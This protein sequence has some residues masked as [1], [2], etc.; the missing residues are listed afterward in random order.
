MLIKRCVVRMLS[1]ELVVLSAGI[2]FGQTYPNRPIRVVTS[3]AGGG[4]DF[5][6]RLIAQGISGPLGQ[7]VV[8][9]NRQVNLL[10]EIVAKAPPD[11]YTMLV[12]GSLLY[13]A[14]LL[15][16]TPYDPVK[17]FS[18]ITLMTR[19]IDVLVVNSSSPVTSVKELIALAKAKPGALNYASGPT[20]SPPHLSAELFKSIAGVNIVRV[21][22]KGG[23]PA[24]NGL[25][26]GEV[27]LAFSAASAAMPQVKSGR[28]RAL[29]VTTAQ[30]SALVP[31]VPPIAASLPGYES[32][33]STGIYAP[34]R[35]PASIVSRLNQEIVRYLNQPDV[36]ERVLNGG[37][38]VVA[39]SSEEFAAMVKSEV[40]K[41]GKVIK[42]AGIKAD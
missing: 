8:V 6:A 41:W 10:G 33:S 36:K 14:P 22:Y 3:P 17:D 23:G 5:T 30:P 25:L 24:L 42:D 7:P 27:Q 4:S 19:S 31:G 9:D 37:E 13:I 2:V 21:P 35:T 12:I 38:E 39:N 20:G 15:E 26:A 34:A 16:Q 11:G 1:F 18:P 28:L 29:G 32:V 40:A